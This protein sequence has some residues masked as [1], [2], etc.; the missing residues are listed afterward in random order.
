[1]LARRRS[2]GYNTYMNVYDFD[3]TI[4]AGDSTLDFT[5]HCILRQPWMLRALPDWARALAIAFNESRISPHAWDKTACKEHFYAYL[6]LLR[7]LPQTLGQFWSTHERKLYGWYLNQKR[8]DDII[9][10]AS[11]R[12][13]LQPICDKLGLTLIASEVDP[14]TGRCTHANC[15]G[16]VKVECFRAVNPDALVDAFYS[17][18][19]S[20]L[21]MA[22]LARRAYF[23]HSGI[24]TDW[25]TK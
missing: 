7:N 25:N 24:I 8:D 4:Y 15:H 17:D 18:S 5:L 3:G 1:M 13:L 14:A 11:P 9:I 12:F 16:P 22:R 6:P 10:S 23:V 19:T 21:P 20:D 2:L